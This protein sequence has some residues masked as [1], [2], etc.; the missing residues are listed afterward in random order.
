MARR[1]HN[2]THMLM[3]L[4][5]LDGVASMWPI[6]DNACNAATSRPSASRA[7]A[8]P[9]HTRAPQAPGANPMPNC[10]LAP[11]AE[12]LGPSVFARRSKPTSAA[13]RRRAAAVPALATLNIES[14]KNSK[15]RRDNRNAAANLSEPPAALTETSPV[16][17]M[18]WR[19]A[20]CAPA[21]ITKACATNCTASGHPLKDAADDAHT[22][23]PVAPG[24]SSPSP[25]KAA[26]VRLPS[27]GTQGG[28][29]AEST[30]VPV[31]AAKS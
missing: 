10:G 8:S 9:T 31:I 25:S 18:S 24:T 23:A 28:Q 5:A 15:P 22:S 27:G 17:L 3:A 7:A 2:D 12:R 6:A 19:P 20:T 13:S 14:C 29:L 4:P 11:S 16:K 30:C 26:T 21:A 1:I